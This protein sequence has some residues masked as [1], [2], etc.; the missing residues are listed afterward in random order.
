[1]ECM[2][3]ELDIFATPIIQTS[4][5]KSE[6]ISYS[7]LAS[8]DNNPSNIEFISYGNGD[9]YR[10]LSSIHILIKGQF[11]KNDGK[12]YATADVDQPTLI[13]NSLHSI[14]RQV[15]ISFNGTP[16]SQIDN[17]YNYR[18]YIENVLNYGTDAAETHLQCALW[19]LDSGELD[20]LT[21]KNKGYTQR[22]VLFQNSNVVEMMGKLHGDILNQPLLLINNVDM[23]IT[24]SLAKKEFFTMSKIDSD[25]KITEAKLYMKHLHIN[26][27]ILLAHNSV[28]EQVN[29]KYY[30]DRVLVKT[31]T[32]PSNLSSISLDNVVSGILPTTLVFG[33]VDSSAYNG[34]LKKN[35]YNFQHLNINQFALYVNGTPVPNTALEMNF[36]KS[37]F[38]RAYHTLFSGTGILHK[39][40]GHQI[41][42]DLFK[43]GYFLLAF[44]LSSSGMAHDNCTELNN[45]GNIRIEARFS[46]PLPVNITC[47]IYNQF[48]SS[49]IELDKYRNVLTSF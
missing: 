11:I 35:P 41:T 43:S 21:D 45:Q 8:I 31:F 37:Q 12:E 17:N 46:K 47:V 27:K 6:E 3:S 24:F 23:R 19:N 39:D 1:M 30:F 40:R 22:K 18:A 28:L 42:K 16:I 4:I 15:N 49:C 5:L 26:P 13:N 38:T 32:V 36:K 29:A 25:F 14:F 34:D 20:E 33:M 10:D 9:T 2:K 48:S 44:D 7:P